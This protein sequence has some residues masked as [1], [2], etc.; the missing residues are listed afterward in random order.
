MVTPIK[1]L[2]LTITFSLLFSF[3]NGSSKVDRQPYIVYMGDA[4]RIRTS[5][6]DDHHRLLMTAIG[7]EK[8]AIDSKIHSYG[9]SFNA[10]AAR[11]LPHE[12]QRLKDMEG[13]VSVFP[14]TML[15]LHTTRSWDYL[16]LTPTVA[17]NNKVESDI[18]VGL[19]DSGIYVSN[20]SFD[21]KGYG[22]PPAK[23][24]GKCQKGGNFTGCNNKVI[25]ARFYNKPDSSDA[26]KAGT[27]ADTEGHGT[28]TASTIAG[29][30][31]VGANFYGLA[32]GTARGGV[33]S[34]RIAMYKVCTEF[35]CSSMDILAGFDDA[36]DDGVDLISISL[37][38]GAGPDYFTDPIAI[39]TFHATQKGIFTACSAG[40]DGPDTYSIVNV[41]PWI[42]TVAASA[43]DRQ[44]TTEVRLGNG[45]NVQGWSINT[46]SPNKRMLPLTS[47]ALAGNKSGSPYG[48]SSSCS[49]GTLDKNKVKGKIIYCG[50]DV[51]AGTDSSLKTLGAAGLLALTHFNLD[52]AFT[53]LLPAAWVTDSVGNTINH[54]IN[55][56]NPIL[57]DIT[58]PG[59]E[60]LAAWTL[61]NSVSEN[62]IDKRISKFNIISGTS[63]AC[64]HA[65]AAAAYVKSFHPD[66]SPAAIRSAL[67]TTATAMKVNIN[68][69][70]LGYG[71]GQIAPVSAVDPGLVYNLTADSYISFLCKEGYNGSALRLISGRALFNCSKYNQTKSSDGLNY[72]SMQ[73]HV[74][75]VDARISAVFYRTVTNV[76]HGK[77]VYKATTKS[78]KGLSI[79][80]SPH[81]LTF[82]NLGERKS[83]K[84]VV[85]GSP[86]GQ[87][88]LRSGSIEWNDKKHRVR[89]PI[90]VFHIDQDD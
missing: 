81:T 57:P 44:F 62:P 66:W 60:I 30:S 48:D 79:S 54:Y 5:A 23:W 65:A 42:L 43:I 88:S 2:L 59:L 46:F 3:I 38:G 7:D 6:V 73:L 63:M 17:R 69:T 40:N 1:F 27:P 8:I 34:A 89:S 75:N 45:K 32:K 52:T 90:V 36:I 14:N 20:P 72:P 56:T 78:S 49:D 28:H 9:K 47:G 4:P 74:D 53:W 55:T 80:V 50:G 87:D 13:V 68:D 64:P 12:A 15:K 61:L 19:L 18:I 25:G 70:E 71:S 51:P 24:K 77:S 85:K 67:M 39:G 84:V 11:L 86:L 10:F 37:G 29:T 41:A 82:N 21:D 16:G 31:I 35:G 76:D 58:A 33:P 83:F 22:P 26:N